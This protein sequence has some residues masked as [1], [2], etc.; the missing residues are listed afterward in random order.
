M[1]NN[2]VVIM[3]G[4]I[5]SRFWP[6]STSSNPKQFHDVLGIGKTLLQLTVDR[7]LPLC[8][9]ENILIV[10]NE[11]YKALVQEQL[12]DFNENQIL[13]EQA[14]NCGIWNI[15]SAWRISKF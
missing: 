9:S 4:G 15:I 5:G 2:F 10:T 13:Q 11:K 8:K 12:P 3:A 1:D 6:M 7:Y 14:F